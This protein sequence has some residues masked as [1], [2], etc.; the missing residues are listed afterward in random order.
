MNEEREFG[1]R[2]DDLDRLEKV[3]YDEG[4]TQFQYDKMG[5]R[6]YASYVDGKYGEWNFYYESGKNRLDY[7]SI[8]SKKFFN[9]EIKK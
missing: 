6:E 4:T 7:L 5:N 3:I 1:Y 9:E 8:Y 2:Y